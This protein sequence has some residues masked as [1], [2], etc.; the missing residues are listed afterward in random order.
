M[1]KE[2]LQN[3]KGAILALYNS[4]PYVNCRHKELQEAYFQGHVNL[5]PGDMA[6]AMTSIK[7]AL[8]PHSRGNITVLIEFLRFLLLPLS[9]EEIVSYEF[10]PLIDPNKTRYE[11]QAQSIEGFK[12]QLAKSPPRGTSLTETISSITQLLRVNKDSIGVVLNGMCNSKRED[13]S[14]P[15]EPVITNYLAQLSLNAL[16]RQVE[17]WNQFVFYQFL[18]TIFY[19]F[20]FFEAYNRLVDYCQ[21]L[22][23]KRNLFLQTVKKNISEMED[24]RVVSNDLDRES[25]SRLVSRLLGGHQTRQQYGFTVLQRCSLIGAVR[26]A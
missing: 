17:I 24:Q 21:T 3:Y 10:L 7:N 2:F 12:E 19:F 9:G 26:C 11:H 4:F 23:H 22:K 5:L 16:T 6:S 8:M 14:P 13:N 15:V 20:R 25:S 18:I 1:S